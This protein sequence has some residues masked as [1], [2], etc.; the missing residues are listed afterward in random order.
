[1]SH[2]HPSHHTTEDHPSLKALRLSMSNT[3]KARGNILFAINDDD[4]LSAYH[5]NAWALH[6]Q[7][8]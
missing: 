8:L 1:M 4:S 2:P 7:G 3:I 6:S 5:R